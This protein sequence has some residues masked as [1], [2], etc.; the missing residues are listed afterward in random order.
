[1]A[2]GI[3]KL[4]EQQRMFEDLGGLSALARAARGIHQI[5]GIDQLHAR[6]NE[7]TAIPN[8]M[9]TA[10]E[11]INPSNSLGQ[12]ISGRL[13]VFSELGE[14]MRIFQD[15]LVLPDTSSFAVLL[16][17]YPAGLSKTI[18]DAIG[19]V[20]TLQ[21]RMA[22]MKTPWLDT[23]QQSLSARAFVDM[24]A[25]G[26]LASSVNSFSARIAGALRV[27]LGDWRDPITF[28]VPELVNSVAR[29][30]LYDSRGFNS[31]LTHFTEEAYQ[32]TVQIAGLMIEEDLEPDVID[33]DDDGVGLNSRAYETLLRFEREIRAF[34]VAVMRQAFGVDWMK[35]QLPPEMFDEWNEKKQ[36]ALQQGAEELPL[37]EYADFTDYKAIIE[38]GDNWKQVFKPIFG[39]P[40]DIRESFQRM[41]PVRIATM[42]ARFIT[43]DD[44]LLLRAETTRVLRRLRRY[45]S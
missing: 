10:L 39:R 37:I 14:S 18:R 2:D 29:F 6:I 21:A 28:D 27:E 25:V 30:E 32:E 4:L 31:N 7:L 24:Q 45:L 33:E 42:H 23:E 17:D 38:R 8:A 44:D 16:K 20:D 15:Q 22:A 26:G 34:I 36:K 40:E 35:H 19:G 43:L 3:K 1:M 11:L 13:R 41:F 9:K 12:L 5:E